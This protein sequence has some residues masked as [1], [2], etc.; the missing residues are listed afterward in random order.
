MSALAFSRAVSIL[1]GFLGAG[2]IVAADL[3]GRVTSLR[4]RRATSNRVRERDRLFFSA[5]RQP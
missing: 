5:R 1:V 2:L 3:N 4:Q